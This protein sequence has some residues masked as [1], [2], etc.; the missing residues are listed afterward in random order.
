[1]GTGL[2]KHCPRLKESSWCE[3]ARPHHVEEMSSHGAKRTGSSIWWWQR[4]D[5]EDRHS[6]AAQRQPQHQLWPRLVAMG[7]GRMGWN[8][9]MTDIHHRFTT[10]IFTCWELFNKETLYQLQL[11]ISTLWSKDKEVVTEINWCNLWLKWKHTNAFPSRRQTAVTLWYVHVCL[12][13][14]WGRCESLGW[15]GVSLAC[16]SRCRGTS[17]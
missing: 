14:F 15:C 6:Q 2:I 13:N 9:T 1:M 10:V 3:L 17:M 7:F 11:P 12:S 4:V 5:V 16:F 8:T